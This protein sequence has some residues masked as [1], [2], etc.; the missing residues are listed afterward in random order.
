[1]VRMNLL[2]LFHRPALTWN[3]LKPIRQIACRNALQSI[4]DNYRIMIF[5][6]NRC[7]HVDPLTPHDLTVIDPRPIPA[8]K[9]FICNSFAVELEAI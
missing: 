8:S 6:D 5:I 9:D 4:Y 1:M 7:R 2:S 3:T